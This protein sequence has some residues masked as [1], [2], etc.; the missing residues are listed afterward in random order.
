MEILTAVVCDSAADYQ[1]KLCILGT[2]DTIWARNFPATHAHCAVALRMLFRDTDVGEH[3]FQVS[4]VDPD[5][6]NALPNGPIRLNVRIDRI[7]DGAF[8]LSRNFI[9]NLQGLP[10][11]EPA[12]YSF[13]VT[14]DSKI[15]ARIP[16]QVVTAE[17][18]APQ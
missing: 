13:D 18:R 14:I 6:R 2:F 15:V 1:G 16:L 8:F 12:Q 11:K 4:F 5:G 3:A 9:L 7:P 17:G 10:L